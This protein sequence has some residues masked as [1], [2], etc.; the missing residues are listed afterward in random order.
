M[1]KFAGPLQLTEALECIDDL[2]AAD[3]S[4][5]EDHAGGVLLSP[6]AVLNRLGIKSGR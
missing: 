2:E 5:A 4:R 6:E 1:A 3:K